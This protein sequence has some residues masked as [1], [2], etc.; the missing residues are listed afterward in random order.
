MNALLPLG[1]LLRLAWWLV[2]VL[3]GAARLAARVAL[4]LPSLRFSP[5]AE[6]SLPQDDRSL[7]RT[8]ASIRALGNYELVA[9]TDKLDLDVDWD[10]K[11]IR[12]VP[13]EE[14]YALRLRP[15][16]L[17]LL[18][19]LR[20][21]L[22]SRRR[23]FHLDQLERL[24]TLL[25]RPAALKHW[26]DDRFFAAL[27]TQGPN[28]L[29]LEGGVSSAELGGRL[30]LDG[31]QRA[32]LGLE[33]E[34]EWFVVD[35][36]EPLADI[37]PG[38]GRHLPPALAMFSEVEGA[39]EPRGVVLRDEGVDRLFTPED[40]EA[41]TLA[42][43]FFNCADF[44]IHEIVSHFLWTHIVAETFAISVAR[45]L[46][47]KHPLR[48][49]LGSH[50]QSTIQQN[51]NAAGVLVVDGG[52]FDTVFTGGDS[53]DKLLA[54]GH[55]RWRYEQMIFPERVE[56]QKLDSLT[57]CPFRDDGLRVWDAVAD[58]VDAYV[59]RY[60]PD[61]ETLRGDRELRCWSQ[62][63]EEALGD[64][65]F[66]AISSVTILREVLTAAL[67]VPVSHTLVNALQYAVYSCP[68]V[69][70]VAMWMPPPKRASEVTADSLLHALP[71]VSAVLETVRATY[72]FSIQYERLGEN[73]ERLLHP[74][75]RDLGRGFREA[76]KEVQAMT[77]QQ[78]ETRRW[79]YDALSPRGL[80]NSVDA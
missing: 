40:G 38:A 23:W 6:V 46:S 24:P 27:R 47:W 59:A 1:F 52:L 63:L 69:A 19:A 55:A 33:Q 41:W 18:Q 65:G 73:L 79:R 74:D 49:L 64:R 25:G 30:A 75:D 66:P 58:Y 39:L 9:A 62:E 37:E 26:R 60:Y 8:R 61:E 5:T 42:R 21:P 22:R 35:Y 54:W 16:K 10:H 4:W 28:P 70:P 78:N 14:R 67:F 68:L 72:G 29:F 77:D 15:A 45:T 12:T 53:K 57:D 32:R 51:A 71:D 7:A 17:L 43:W 80:S 20:V 11:T 34:Q 13:F 36:S 2:C 3:L 76:L 31:E 50:L 44:T 56:A 48:R